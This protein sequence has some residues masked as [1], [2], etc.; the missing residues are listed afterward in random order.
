M[1]AWLKERISIVNGEL[2]IWRNRR[3]YAIIEAK[4]EKGR[5][6]T[7]IFRKAIKILDNL[8]DGLPYPYT[9]RDGKDYISAM[10]VADCKAEG[11]W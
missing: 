1:A 7:G 8:R 5:L 6:S 11:Y 2:R 9:E 3:H 10:I 4:S